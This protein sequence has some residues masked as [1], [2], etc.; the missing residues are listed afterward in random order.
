MP[1]GEISKI[2]ISRIWI[3]VI[4]DVTTK[5]VLGYHVTLNPEY[6]SDDVLQTIRN[7]LV[8]WEPKTLTIPG[9]TGYSDNDGFPSS[10]IEG[11]FGAKWQEFTLDNGMANKADQVKKFVID[12]L[13]ANYCLGPVA[14]PTRRGSVERFFKR[15]EEDFFHRLPSTTGS[16]PNDVKNKIQLIML[17][18]MIFK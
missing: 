10:K 8:R 2:E 6:N 11:S 14:N 12:K 16:G 3:L 18:N 5:C 15:L 9:L 1:T 17:V 13:H 7:S 4:I